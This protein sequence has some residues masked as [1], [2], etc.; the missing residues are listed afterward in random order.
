MTP[1]ELLPC[2]CAGTY[3]DDDRHYQGDD[4]TCPA[5]YRS[6]VAAALAEKNK[7]LDE[8]QAE[9]AALREQNF[10]HDCKTNGQ[11]GANFCELEGTHVCTL[12][13]AAEVAAL[14]Q[15]IADLEGR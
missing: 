8:L 5:Y 1:E 9:V 4:W 11:R 3:P 10:W 13:Q 7:E 15:R 14:R 12:C 2:V 6:Q